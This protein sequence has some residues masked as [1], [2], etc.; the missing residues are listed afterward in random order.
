MDKG[1][2]ATTLKKVRYLLHGSEEKPGRHLKPMSK[3]ISN[4]KW[5]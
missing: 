5:G 3:R 4:M 1:G 2:D